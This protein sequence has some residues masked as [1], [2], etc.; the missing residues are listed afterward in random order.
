MLGILC[1]VVAADNILLPSLGDSTSAIVS[2]EDERAI[3]A[4]WLRQFRQQAPLL[5]DPILLSYLENLIA[6]LVV[7]SELNDRNLTIIIVDN[8][9][10]NAFA[11]P[12]GVIGINSGLLLF[13]NTEDELAS[14]LAHE[15]GHLSQRH[16]ARSI[17]E[18]QRNTLPTMAALLASIL[19]AATAGGDAGTAAIMATQA[20]SLEHR[21]K[22]SRLHETEADRAGADTL[23]R[24]GRNP[25]A[26]GDMFQNMQRLYRFN[27]TNV[28]EYLLTHPLT[29]NRIADARNNTL[30]L[31]GHTETDNFDFFMMAARVQSSTFQTPNFAIKFFKSALTNGLGNMTAN[32][33][34]LVL[35]L[36]KAHQLE[37]AGPLAAQLQ[38]KYPLYIPFALAEIDVFIAEGNFQK[39]QEKLISLNSINPGNYPISMKYASLLLQ[40]GE[41]NQA[42][43]LL[44]QQIQNHPNSPNIWFELSK[45]EAQNGRLAQALQARS[46]YHFL[47]GRYEPALKV[48]YQ[49][50]QHAVGN[51]PLL[52]QIQ[53]QMQR[54]ELFLK[55]SNRQR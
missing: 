23:V 42:I 17:D 50:K 6:S 49:A 12:G 1:P 7:H 35:A 27:G 15:I 20:A 24:S 8:K 45:A 16:F 25:K 47:N 39:A 22:F 32:Q 46:Q 13:A 48:L 31:E 41:N 38:Q 43:T 54:L 52:F 55:R 3:G 18:A 9:S 5:D 30:N 40:M 14:V 34:G 11:V 44:R 37:E 2:P 21:L 19:I 29:N 4:T 10:L 53:E 36:T 28:P 33:Y 26:M 51:E